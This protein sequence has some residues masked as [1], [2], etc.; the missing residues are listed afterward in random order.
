MTQIHQFKNNGYNIVMDICSGSVHVVDDLVYAAVALATENGGKNY[1]HE[2][3]AKLLADKYTKEDIREALEGIDE[4]IKEKLAGVKV[5]ETGSKWFGVTYKED[6]PEV[7]NSIKKLIA[8][9]KYPANL[10]N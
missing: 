8:D 10:W 9:G 7:V 6:K 3:V 5:L 2:K 1:D 4:L